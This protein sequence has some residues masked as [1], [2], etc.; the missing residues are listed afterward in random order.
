MK[1]D[2]LDEEI[3]ACQARIEANDKRLLK[4]A[5]YRKYLFY[6]SLL[7]IGAKLYLYFS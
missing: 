2:Q 7:V 1:D 5:K 3:K 6:A 4:L